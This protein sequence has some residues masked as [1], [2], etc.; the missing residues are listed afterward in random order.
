MVTE[1]EARQTFGWYFDSRAQ[2]PGTVSAVIMNVLAAAQEAGNS[3]E[4]VAQWSK[5]LVVHMRLPLTGAMRT[6]LQKEFSDL[7]FL[8]ND[9]D[10]HYAPSEDFFDELSATAISFPLPPSL[11]G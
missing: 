7:R 5:A 3:I 11:S 2:G 8:R 6:K 9:K 4:T 10:A 1:D